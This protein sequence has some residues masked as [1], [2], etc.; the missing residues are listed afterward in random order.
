MALKV[1]IMPP[2]TTARD[3]RAATNTTATLMRSLQLNV[4][5]LRGMYIALI[6]K[7][8]DVAQKSRCSHT[9]CRISHEPGETRVR[10][11]E[12]TNAASVTVA[13]TPEM[14]KISLL[15]TNVK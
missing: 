15:T 6:T 12:P 7:M 2:M 3:A 1:G 9:L 10:L 14:P 13:M 5:R 11:S 8:N 4:F